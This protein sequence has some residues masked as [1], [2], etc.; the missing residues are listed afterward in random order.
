MSYCG[1]ARGQFQFF[2]HAQGVDRILPVNGPVMR[3]V[4]T[5]IPSIFPRLRTGPALFYTSHPQ[6]RAQESM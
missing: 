5:R 6:V 4:Q 2:L 1:V 3:V